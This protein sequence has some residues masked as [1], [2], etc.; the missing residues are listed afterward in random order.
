MELLGSFIVFL[1][2]LFAVLQRH[3]LTAGLA[4]LSI[5]YALQVRAT[6]SHA[7][8]TRCTSS[9]SNGHGSPQISSWGSVQMN[10]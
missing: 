2:C 7:L 9:N 4:G 6:A 8:K 3:S 5:S 10:V 1:A